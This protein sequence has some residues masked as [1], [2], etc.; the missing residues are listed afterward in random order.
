MS[1]VPVRFSENK[2]RPHMCK[3]PPPTPL[4]GWRV[5]T[6]TDLTPP[7]PDH[8]G[9]G[10]RVSVSVAIAVG[11]HPVPSRTR[12]LSPPAPMVLHGRPCG[13]VGRRRTQPEE[14]GPPQPGGPSSIVLDSSIH[15]QMMR[16]VRTSGR[17]RRQRKP[18]GEAPPAVEAGEDDRIA[19]VPH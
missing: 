10:C 1:R 18:G 6:T 16:V 12:K 15:R 14:E 7:P 4:S 13:R 11:K 8:L 2:Q 17:A 19:D 9:G 3:N 5:L